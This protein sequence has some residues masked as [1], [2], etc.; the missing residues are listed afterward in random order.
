MPRFNNVRFISQEAINSLVINDANTCPEAFTPLQFC[1]TYTRRNLKHYGMAMVHPIT[2][3]HIT[4]Y[5]KLMQDPATSEVWMMTFGKD[6]G[7]MYQGD[8]KTKTKGTDAI[9]VMDPK[10]IPNIPKNQPPAYAKVVVAYCPQKED[11]Y[12]IRIT[13]GGNLINYP[14]ELTMRTANMMTAKLHWN[15][16][17]STPNACYMCL[18]IRIFYLTAT[19]ECYKYMKMPISLFPPWIVAQY[20]LITKVIGGYVYLQMQK[21]VWGLP[22]A[23]KLLH[24][25]LA[26]HDY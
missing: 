4:S 20:N 25:R 8:N 1:P 7:G 11:S 19:F 13:T 23:N 10:D 12:Q 21:A 22:Q 15:S 2:G 26:L 18:D 5:C 6:F 3:E 14:G 9:F 24:K 17:L 16:I